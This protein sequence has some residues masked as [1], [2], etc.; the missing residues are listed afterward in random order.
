MCTIGNMSALFSYL[1][2]NSNGTYKQLRNYN[3]NLLILISDLCNLEAVLL[4]TCDIGL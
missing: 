1:V 3:A 2:I 4:A